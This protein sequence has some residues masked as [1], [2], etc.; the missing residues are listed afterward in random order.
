MYELLADWWR[1][2]S[3]ASASIKNRQ[4]TLYDELRE[5]NPR[6]YDLPDWSFK[7]SWTMV[8]T[9]IVVIDK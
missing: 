1:L 7:E 5:L 4:G 6:Y 8:N 9:V 3:V 2:V